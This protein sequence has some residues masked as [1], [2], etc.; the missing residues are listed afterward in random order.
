MASRGIPNIS[1]KFIELNGGIY[2]TP[3]DIHGVNPKGNLPGM[4]IKVLDTNRPF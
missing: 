4:V 1:G 3:W 2:S